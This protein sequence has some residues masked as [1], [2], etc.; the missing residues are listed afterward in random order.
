MKYEVNVTEFPD[1]TKSTK[2][3]HYKEIIEIPN[4]QI[5]D[6]LICT[7]CGFSLYP[8]CKEWCHNFSYPKK[9]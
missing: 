1:N 3:K 7:F 5:K 6:E 8:K 4:E 9:M 2:F